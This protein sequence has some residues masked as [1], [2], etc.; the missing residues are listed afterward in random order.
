MFSF[1]P[2]I[3]TL[4][5]DNQSYEYDQNGKLIPLI[6]GN[7]PAKA[8]HNDIFK[9]T[10]GYNNQLRLNL[11]FKNHQYSYD[12]K[13]RISLDLGQQKDQMYFIDQYSILNSFKTKLN[14]KILK[15]NVNAAFVYEENKATNSNRIGLFNRVY[16]NSLL[17]PVS[18]SMLR[19][20]FLPMV[21]REA[22]AS[23]QT[24]RIFI[25]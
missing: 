12:E 2:D 15:F 25:L 14:S 20:F 6:N 16:Q 11:F 17:T 8:Y 5:F 9:T 13:F 21:R 23:L 7:S 4:Q 10:V 1:G 3:S 22:T 18:F 19:R 24:I